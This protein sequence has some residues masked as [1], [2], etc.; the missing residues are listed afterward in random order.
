M[1]HPT[2]MANVL[3]PTS[4]FY[5]LYLHNPERQNDN[6]HPSRSEFSDSLDSGAFISVLNYP[7]YLTIAKHLKITCNIKTNH[8]SNHWVLQVKL[9]FSY[10][11]I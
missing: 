2:E 6:D 4:W 10:Y 11:T 3:K 9:K 1:Y 7:T 8:T 5:S